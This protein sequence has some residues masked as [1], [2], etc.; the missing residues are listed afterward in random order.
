MNLI[1][2]LQA[3]VD[4]QFPDLGVIVGHQSDNTPS[5][6]K[7]VSCFFIT[8]PVNGTA[9]CNEEELFMNPNPKAIIRNRVIDALLNIRDLID[10]T[11]EK[12]DATKS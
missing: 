11:L 3:E 12:C 7:K 2:K 10:E 6:S 1:N 8:I 5:P 4:R 9:F